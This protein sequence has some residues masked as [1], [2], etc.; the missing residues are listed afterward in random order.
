MRNISTICR[1]ELYAYF[2][3]P[4][5]W[6]LLAIFAL[7]SGY[8]TVSAHQSD[9]TTPPATTVPDLGARSVFLTSD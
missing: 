7:L 9:D 5:A 3:S 6:V 8:F 1:R 2:A 4:I